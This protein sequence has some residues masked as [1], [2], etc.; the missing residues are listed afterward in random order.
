MAGKPF[1]TGTQI[2]DGDNQSTVVN[3]NMRWFE[4]P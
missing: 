1:V 3:I 4:I 2:G